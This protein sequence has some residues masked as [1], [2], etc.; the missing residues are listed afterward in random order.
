MTKKTTL[1]KKILTRY[2]ECMVLNGVWIE[3]VLGVAL[4]KF[5][6]EVLINRI[7]DLQ[8]SDAYSIST[9]EIE[10]LRRDLSF[11]EQQKPI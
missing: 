8:S 5:N 1:R 6:Y 3:N 11:I 2:V 9:E 4:R 10:E 7:E